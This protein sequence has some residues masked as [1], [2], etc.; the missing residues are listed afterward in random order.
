MGRFDNGGDSGGRFSSSPTTSASSGGGGGGIGGFLNTIRKRAPKGLGLGEQLKELWNIPFGLGHLAISAFPGGQKSMLPDAA[1]GMASSAL[2]T[3]EW[4]DPLEPLA[5]MYLGKDAPISAGIEHV[6]KSL[7]GD[8]FK[9]QSYFERARERGALSPLTEDL[10]NVS[11]AGGIAGKLGKLGDV[12]KAAAADFSTSEAARLASEA[13]GTKAAAKAAEAAAKA[14][15]K[16]STV[17][18]AA[19]APEDVAN[20][21]TFLENAHA[22]EH[23]YKTLFNNA[24]R[25]VLR[26]ADAATPGG[27]AVAE[28]AG[29]NPEVQDYYQKYGASFGAE[30]PQ[31]VG[32]KGAMADDA[33]KRVAQAY[34]GLNSNP[35]DPR[36]QEAYGALKQESAAQF[37]YMTDPVDRGGLG[38]K[39]DFVPRDQNPYNA[40]G[41]IQAVADAM[42][43]DVAQNKHLYVDMTSPDEGHP[44]LTPD[45]NNVFRAVHDFFGHQ[46]AGTYFDRAGEEVAYQ[47]HA[48]MFSPLAREALATETRGQN[49]FLNYS[50]FNDARRAAGLE[51]QFPEQKAALLPQEFVDTAYG[52]GLNSDVYLG[53]NA[54]TPAELAARASLGPIPEWATQSVDHLPDPAKRALAAL[55]HRI[56]ARQLRNVV[57]DRRILN[58]ASRQAAL[59]SPAVQASIDAAKELLANKQ[60][61][62][63][64]P[65]TRE[66]ASQM[67]GAEIMRRQ[68]GLKLLADEA[69]GKPELQAALKE[70]GALE[71]TIPDNLMSPEL[72]GSIQRATDLWAQESKVKEAAL[73]SD[74]VG[75][76]GLGQTDVTPS[77]SDQALMKKNALDRQRL[78]KLVERRAKE[79]QV[80]ERTVARADDF[81]A[82]RAEEIDFLRK[83]GEAA[84]AAFDESRWP[85][86]MPKDPAGWEGVVQSTAENGGGTF[87]PRTGPEVPKAYGG[88][89]TGWASSILDVATVPVEQWAAVNP[90]TGVT[91][92]AEAMHRVALDFQDLIAANPDVRIGTWV[93]DGQVYVDLSQH[94]LNGKAMTRDQAL[95]L[96]AARN[97]LAV[98]DFAT[99]QEVAPTGRP[100]LAQQFIKKMFSQKS[101]L[102]RDRRAAEL[103]A[104]VEKG[105]YTHEQIDA[106]MNMMDA[107]AWA[108]TEAGK[109][110]HP[111]AAYQAYKVAAPKL[112][113]K[114]AKDPAALLQAVVPSQDLKSI[115]NDAR[116]MFANSDKLAQWY[117]RSHDAIEGYLRGKEVT[118]LDG[119]KI[120]AADL[121]YQL[122][123]VTSIN[124]NPLVNLG[125]ALTGVKNMVEFTKNLKTSEVQRL[126]ED[127]MRTPGEAKTNHELFQMLTDKTHM[128]TAPAKQYVFDILSGK[129]L[130]KWTPD[131]LHQGVDFWARKTSKAAMTMEKVPK[132]L[133]ERLG[134]KQAFM[135]HY[136]SSAMAK[137]MSFWDNLRDPANSQS[138]TLD[139][140][141]GRGFGLGESS[142]WGN[143][144]RYSDFANRIRDLTDEINAG[145]GPEAQLKP[146]NVQALFW[147]YF[148]QEWNKQVR[149]GAAPTVAK[150]I[151][152]QGRDF[153]DFFAKPTKRIKDVQAQ[154]DSLFADPNTLLQKMGNDIKGALVM[155]TEESKMPATMAFFQSADA[156]TLVHEHGH[157]IRQLLPAPMLRAVETAYG[158]AD[159]SWSRAQEERFAEEFTNYLAGASV[160]DKPHLTGAFNM[161]KD[162]LSEQWRHARGAFFKEASPEAQAVLDHLLDP[163]PA[164]YVDLGIPGLK[165]G[166]Q[167]MAQ[168]ARLAPRLGETPAQMYQRG[169]KGGKSMVEVSRIEDAIKAKQ[170]AMA[171]AM[172]V[173]NKVQQQLVEGALPADVQSAALSKRVAGR[174]LR[175]AKSLDNPSVARTPAVW[176]PLWGAVRELTDLAEK[177]P[178]LAAQ[179]EGMPD[180][181]SKVMEAARAK[182][183]EPTHV[184][185]FTPAEV[186]RLVFGGIGFGGARELG[187]EVEAGTRKARAGFIPRTQS[188]EALMAS[189]VEVAREINQNALVD[190]LEQY[191]AQDIPAGGE[192][193]K[194]YRAWDP[195]RNYI[196]TGVKTDE[197][198]V[199]AVEG[200][201]TA[202][203]TKMIPD[204]VAKTLES[205]GKDYSHW[206]QQ[207]LAKITNPWR[208]LILTWT[209]R[210]YV[211]NFMGNVVLASAEGVKLQDWVRAWHSYK[212]GFRDAKGVVGHSIVAELGDHTSVIPRAGG[213]Q[214]IRDAAE[215][216]RATGG[217]LG[218]AKEAY[219]QAAHTMQRANEVVDEMARAAV[220]FK[221]KRI[222]MSA[223]AAISRAAKALVDYNDLSPFER[224]IVKSVVPFYSWQKAVL[225][226]VAAF[227]IDHP[228]A[229]GMTM[230]IGKL[231]MD[232]TEQQGLP[233]AYTGMF[234]VPGLGNVN[235]KGANPFADA[236]ALMS[237]QGIAASMNPFLGAAV[238][239]AMAP[240]FGFVKHQQMNDFGQAVPDTHPGEDVGR[241]AT[242]TPQFTLGQQVTG[243]APKG[244]PGPA[245]GLLRF[246]GVPGYSDQQLEA[247]KTRVKKSRKKLGQK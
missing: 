105:V 178:E 96:G 18:R 156:T 92:G 160:A 234:P 222:G 140:W 22:A 228:V 233:E 78:G 224:N 86:A 131:T 236:D 164:G 57:G 192:I 220:Y 123:A 127:F 170:D 171:K 71:H 82:R 191:V 237:P 202:K 219:T 98:M 203:P 44:L 58:E 232:L 141:M 161:V 59:A 28:Q 3:L 14:T 65:I 84:Q 1:R 211:N 165:E 214:G 241:I 114:V 38:I 239:N 243:N 101:P 246:V 13:P 120:D 126:V 223:E 32:A 64:T 49:T 179:L 111:D 172:S 166:E 20:R 132:D 87:D 19:L 2:S 72:E 213:M 51:A 31:P 99:G 17:D 108:M 177:N 138:V 109:V 244:A 136:G 221:S 106:T 227:P 115:Y 83:R 247:I 163:G 128:Y 97:Q 144:G 210:W 54:T 187:K 200:F 154:L 73:A 135:E 80:A 168:R 62:D 4:T 29:V 199:P 11:L 69:I 30:P 23:P 124:T 194:G 174:E 45:E 238:K 167:T 75:D 145:L 35:A 74:R 142:M 175:L 129:T 68:T 79:A 159:H 225:K 46:R 6:G 188:I 43:Q 186:K 33:A 40:A 147:V 95:L 205:Y 88:T 197:G 157:L 55:E 9:P 150:G 25:P 229:V 226:H 139:V 7:L 201:A 189:Q 42:K 146:H 185:S 121:A 100:D 173:R 137:I 50:D 26:A 90:A 218:G 76:K 102:Y 10:M 112:A 130:D 21:T 16:A 134:E 52:H 181:L 85:K 81:I 207:A 113:A 27:T 198:A 143:L 47:H 183:F 169:V 67:I 193:P 195:V 190:H 230:Q 8:Q 206:S 37:K 12:G 56:M 41:D 122:L 103:R 116:E 162:A 184:R 15:E 66:M 63:G 133:I 153:A 245:Q 180:T 212:A 231:N 61:D 118:L 152:G 119:T 155:P 91:F 204:A 110:D 242:G 149:E 240:Q 125:N 151:E 148:E 5:Q 209:P 158:V 70:M 117:N 215:I 94:T 196:M 217:K 36:V 208:A 48:Q 53:A 77:A 34:E 216:G 24:I 235:L 182:G 104:Y 89:A 107:A 39:V 93:N 176:Q 60:L